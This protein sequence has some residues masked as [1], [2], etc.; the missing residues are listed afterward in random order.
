MGFRVEDRDNR[1]G[2]GDGRLES[3]SSDRKRAGVS[4]K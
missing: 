4:F 3:R 1:Q 2:N